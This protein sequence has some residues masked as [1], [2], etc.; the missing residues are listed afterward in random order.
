MKVKIL[1]DNYGQPPY[2]LGWGVCYW[3][4]EG[5]LFDAGEKFS[6]LAENAKIMKLDFSQIKKI[7]LSHEHW[8]H[9]GGLE[10]VLEQNKDIV[11]YAPSGFSQEF[12]DKVSALAKELVLVDDFFMLQPGLYL[13]RP[14]EVT[15]KDIVLSESYLVFKAKMGLVMLCGCSHPGIVNL[16]RQAK[17]YFQEKVYAVMGGFHLLKSEKRVIELVAKELKSEGVEYVGPS[18]CSGALAQEVFRR[19]WPERFLEVEIGREFDFAL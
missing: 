3:L 1:F 2:S 14:L 7:A 8:D 18:H 6:Y 11:V 19:L 5:V 15:Y 13:S 9:T 17:D 12:K 4:S 10:G 16:V